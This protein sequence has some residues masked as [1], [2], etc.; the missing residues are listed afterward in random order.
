MGSEPSS[1]SSRV[2]RQGGPGFLISNWRWLYEKDGKPLVIRS[3]LFFGFF[4]ETNHVM[5]YAYRCSHFLSSLTKSC[6][7]PS[8]ASCLRLGTC[9]EYPQITLCHSLSEPLCIPAVQRLEFHISVIIEQLTCCTFPCWSG[10]FLLFT[11]MTL[12]PN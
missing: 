2:I 12:N 9:T 7:L 11:C 10:C 6:I 5:V 1:P 8:L 3:S 4:F